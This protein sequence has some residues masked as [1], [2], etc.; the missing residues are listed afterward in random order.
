MKNKKIEAKDIDPIYAQIAFCINM[1]IKIMI[2]KPSEL[3]KYR[4][5]LT[6]FSKPKKTKD[7]TGFYDPAYPIF[8]CVK[9]KKDD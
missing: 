8:V 4:E 3:R 5:H 7:F 1:G 2:V 9:N 6:M